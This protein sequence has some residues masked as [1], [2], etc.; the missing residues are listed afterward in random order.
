MHYRDQ[1]LLSNMNIYVYQNE[2][3]DSCQSLISQL[4][5]SI[6]VLYY[7]PVPHYTDMSERKSNGWHPR[8]T[9]RFMS[10]IPLYTME[11]YEHLMH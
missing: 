10:I 9:D 1:I 11:L 2:L 8:E 6:P 5:G 7:T 3:E 4:I